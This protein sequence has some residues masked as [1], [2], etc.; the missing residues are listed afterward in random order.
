MPRHPLACRAARLTLA[1]ASVA[2]CA[3]EPAHVPTPSA[4][5]TAIA[6]ESGDPPAAVWPPRGNCPWPEHCALAGRCWQN[7]DGQSCSARS[8][9]DCAQSWNCRDAGL[10]WKRNGGSGCTAEC[11]PT[12][13]AKSQIC[14]RYGQCH[15][16]N[17]PVSSACHPA[18]DADCANSQACRE[19][20]LCQFN[21]A[22]G[23]CLAASD[24]ACAAS[25][26]CKEH[27]LCRLHDNQCDVAGQ[28]D[29]T[30][31]SRCAESGECDFAVMAGGGMCRVADKFD[32]RSSLGCRRHG[33]CQMFAGQNL[34]LPNGCR[35]SSAADCRQ[36]EDCQQRGMCGW[37]AYA[38]ECV[39]GAN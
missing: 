18:S 33:R 32:C 8:D 36:S 27:G 6:A 2:A 16:P 4:A 39:R 15:P 19:S 28:D 26:A 3:H 29:C 22:A 38:P 17:A 7:D 23:A 11:E 30:R 21:A 9:T 31:A 24:A 14:R 20:G 35:P 25:T 37:F 13:C 1:V 10:C 12:T 5:A 34:L